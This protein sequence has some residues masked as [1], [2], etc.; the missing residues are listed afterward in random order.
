MPRVFPHDLEAERSLLG[1]M[2]I[3]KD[4]CQDILNKCVESDFYEE[5]HKF[6][7]TAMSEL[8]RQM[9][10]VDVTT[11]TSYLLDHNQLDK[12]GGV[13]YLRVLSDSV[14]TLAHSEYYL[15]IIH[16]K[17]ILRKIINETTRIAEG[18][19]GD[20]EDIDGFIDDSE[21]TMLAI[22]RDRNAGEFV[23]VKHVIREVTDRLNKLQSID[24]NISGIR[25]KFRDLDKITSG[26]QKGDL[27][28][29][30]A[31]L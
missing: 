4:V 25:T 14:P 17:A 30:A 23:D 24:G 10:P 7:F 26:L 2:L 28:I 21:K 31:L 15:K 19:Y 6:L 11:V 29:L 13:E 12:V 8:S 20:I 5:S 27:I 1:A 3:S 16:N 9:I 22:T 18:A